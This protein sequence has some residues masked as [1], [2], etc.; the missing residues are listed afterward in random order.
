MFVL[1]L[2]LAALAANTD[3]DTPKRLD[4]FSLYDHT[5]AF[6][7]LYYNTDQ[8]ALVLFIQG[9]GCPIARKALP[10]LKRI[11]EAYGDKDVLFWMLNSNLQ[12]TRAAIRR[13]AEKYDIQMPIL[14]DETQL[15]G[16]NLGL[17]RT[18]EVLVVDTNTWTIAYRGPINDRI[19]YESERPKA[20]K[21]YL[22]DALDNILAGKEVRPKVVPPRGCL[23]TFEK[24]QPVTYTEHVAPLLKER[25]SDCHVT[26]G[27]AP[28]AMSDYTTV[29]GWSYMIREVIRTKRMPPWHADP[30]VGSFENAV[31]L[32]NEERRMLV[33]WVESGAPRGE[34]PDPLTGIKA[35]ESGWELG[36]PD[37]IVTL[38]EQTI[39][40]DGVVDYRYITKRVD[41]KEGKWLRAVDFQPSNLEVT[42]HAVVVIL[43]PTTQRLETRNFKEDIFASYVPGRTAEIL[44]EGTGRYLPPGSVLV[45]Q[46]HYTATGREEKDRS[47]MALYFH[48][49]KPKHAYKLNAAWNFRIAIP[50]GA[51]NHEERAVHTFKNEV[52]LYSFWPHMHFR[53]KSMRYEAV[54][55]DGTVEKLISV[56]NYNFNWQRV[57]NLAQPRTLPAGTKLRVVAHFD[58]SNLNTYNPDPSKTVYFGEQSFEEMLIGYFT[59]RDKVAPHGNT[60]KGE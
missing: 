23:I 55:P 53:G 60:Q 58:N 16:K 37:L 26:G 13:E 28:W 3:T 22:R 54:F 39:P 32:S 50:P 2:T 15:V 27:I 38:D 24:P 42:H 4:N 57:Y 14:V 56:P 59:Y 33:H 11:Q 52:V 46:M 1:L 30:H 36:E 5:G 19:G 18:A 40:A 20:G 10:E 12:D 17:T 34:G 51:K 21:N 49:Q 25:C 44:P 6:Q 31:T 35:K 43:D 29:K 48:D 47:Q 9:N 41:I 45:F 7:N 8:K